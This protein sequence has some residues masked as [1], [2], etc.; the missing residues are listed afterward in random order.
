MR[1]INQSINLTTHYTNLVSGPPCNSF[2]HQA[3]QGFLVNGVGMPAARGRQHVADSAFHEL[4][5]WWRQR[6]AGTNHLFIVVVVVA[7]IN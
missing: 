3:R 2:P 7:D 4:Q 6:K 5:L 1:S